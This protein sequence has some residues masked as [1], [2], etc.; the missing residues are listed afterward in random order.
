[1]IEARL[2]GSL[3]L[4]EETG[5]FQQSNQKSLKGDSI[6]V[7]FYLWI[8]LSGPEQWGHCLVHCYMIRGK[9]RST[10]NGP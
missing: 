5:A 4:Y 1:M 9:H 6:G 7:P 2:Y 3:G 10:G 8:M